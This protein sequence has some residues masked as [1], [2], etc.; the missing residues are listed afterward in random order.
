[1]SIISGRWNYKRKDI[2]GWIMSKYDF[3]KLIS[4]SGLLATSLVLIMVLVSAPYN[5]VSLLLFPVF[6]FINRYS[7]KVDRE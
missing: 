6:F 4:L 5:S 7:Y 3:S 1:M 2:R